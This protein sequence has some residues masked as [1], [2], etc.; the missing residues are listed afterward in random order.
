MMMKAWMMIVCEYVI[1]NNIISKVIINEGGSPLQV[2]RIT[3]ILWHDCSIIFVL[4]S[5]V[6]KKW[7]L[8]AQVLLIHEFSDVFDRSMSLPP[9]IVMLIMDCLH[10]REYD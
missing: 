8:L 9:C 7:I 3:P 2:R 4:C 10:G 5:T 1:K 6:V